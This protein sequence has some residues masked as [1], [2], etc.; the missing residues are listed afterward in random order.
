VDRKL[1]FLA[2]GL[3]AFLLIPGFILPSGI[4]YSTQTEQFEWGQV[5]TRIT[6]IGTYKSDEV[7]HQVVMHVNVLDSSECK[8]QMKTLRLSSAPELSWDGFVNETYA[9]GNA[10]GAMA[11]NVTVNATVSFSETCSQHNDIQLNASLTAER[12]R[13]WLWTIAFD[14]LMSV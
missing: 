5:Q 1:L 10:T 6:P 2:F 9:S 7:L 4:Q 12:R 14:A 11:D 13:Y 3:V 8:F